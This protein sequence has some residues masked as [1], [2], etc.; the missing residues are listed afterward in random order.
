[1]C[2]WILATIVMVASGAS[3]AELETPVGVPVPPEARDVLRNAGNA[4]L[5]S[6]L[7]KTFANPDLESRKAE[8]EA[9]APLLENWLATSR[10]SAM[11]GSNPLPA[12]VRSAMGAFY[13]D[14]LLDKVRFKIGEPNLDNAAGLLITYGNAIAVT[15]IDLIVFKNESD[16]D[17]LTLWAHE[18]R[19]VQQF[20]DWTTRKFA[21]NYILDYQAVENEAVRA[22][23]AYLSILRGFGFNSGKVPR[24]CRVI[25]VGRKG[26]Q[27]TTLL[28]LPQRQSVTVL[29]KAGTTA[30][31]T[32]RIFFTDENGHTETS[33]V[34]TQ[35]ES[36]RDASEISIRLHSDTPSF[37]ATTDAICFKV[38]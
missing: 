27:Q 21:Y 16:A 3:A 17:D 10:D 19:H 38:K 29:W 11:A 8:A 36:T 30:N 18:L 5:K 26:T 12:Y 9:A 24:D 32:R 37:P 20:A 1:M 4:I 28:S 2:R 23:Q 15:L 13:D 34:D 14:R 35:R 22:Q 7:E 25:G 31:V 33:P 6:P